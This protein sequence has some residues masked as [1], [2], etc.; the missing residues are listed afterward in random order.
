[1]SQGPKK[2]FFQRG[3]T[4]DQQAHQKMFNINNHQQIANQNHDDI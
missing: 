4:Y 1:M 2:A 3:H